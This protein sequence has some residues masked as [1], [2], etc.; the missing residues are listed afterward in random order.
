[1]IRKLV[2][3]ALALLLGGCSS[4]MFWKDA[5]PLLLVVNIEAANNINP[6]V[7]GLASPLE[8][9]IYQLSDSEAFNQAS[10]IDL[11]SD[12]QGTLKADLLSK[13]QLESVFPG[14]TRQLTM[15]QIAETQYIGVVAAFADYREAKSKALLPVQA[16]LPIAVN[17]IIDGI[18]ISVT[19][20]ED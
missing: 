16:G 19:G 9:R 11:Y 10:F 8:M 1:M 14:D 12:D 17:I 3:I 7:D 6:N 4:W 2:V 15:P 20:Q 18:N 5:S 13:R